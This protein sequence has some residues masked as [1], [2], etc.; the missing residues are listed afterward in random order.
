[1]TYFGTPFLCIRVAHAGPAV[2]TLLAIL[3]MVPRTRSQLGRK[4]ARLLSSKLPVRRIV[5]S[6]ALA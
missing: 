1:M 5:R 4:Q 2:R 6:D 3:R